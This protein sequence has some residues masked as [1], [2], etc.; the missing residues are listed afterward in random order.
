[1]VELVAQRYGTALFE[2]ALENNQIDEMEQEVVCLKKILSEEKELIELI[3]NP[4][5]TLNDRKKVVEDIF[6][7]KISDNLLGLIDLTI[8]KKRQNMLL[9][10]FE[11]FLSKV[12]EHKGVVIVD[13]TVYTLLSKVQETELIGRL[14]ALT[15]KTIVL[16]QKVDKSLV[17]GLIIR[18]GDRIMNHSVKGMIGAMSKQLLAQT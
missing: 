12:N 16:N 18:M 13:V 4:K 6:K 17:G 10:I 8:H 9:Q 2:L 3:S 7:D 15:K 1:M 11:D 5:I 14:E